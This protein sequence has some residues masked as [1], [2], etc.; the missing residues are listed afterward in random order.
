M[1][2]LDTD[3]TYSPKIQKQLDKLLADEEA[4]NK[5]TWAYY[6]ELKKTNPKLYLDPKISVQMDKDAIALGDAFGLPN[7]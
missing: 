6:Q 1:N 3:A 2:D 4:Q 5:R 7:D